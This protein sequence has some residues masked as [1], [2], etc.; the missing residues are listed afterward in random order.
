MTIP[1]GVSAVR[2]GQPFAVLNRS[3][4]STVRRA[5]AF[6]QRRMPALSMSPALWT[7]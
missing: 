5:T 2:D 7:N 3:R 6:S 1:R 4:S